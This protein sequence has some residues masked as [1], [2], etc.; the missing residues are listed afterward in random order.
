VSRSSAVHCHGLHDPQTRPPVPVGAVITFRRPVDR[1][2]SGSR[3][4]CPGSGPAGVARSRDIPRCGGALRPVGGRSRRS[5][6]P[7]QSHAP[8]R[9]DECAPFAEIAAHVARNRGRGR[10]RSVP[11]GIRTHVIGVKGRPTGTGRAR[12][13]GRLVVYSLACVRASCCSRR[14]SSM[15]SYGQPAP[16]PA[17]AQSSEQTVNNRVP[18]PHTST[19]AAACGGVV[20]LPPGRETE[21]PRRLPTRS[22]RCAA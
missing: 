17:P 20:P 7:A 10:K 12:N 22:P 15:V 21:N 14:S 13:E 2:L 19:P 6:I 8:H 3:S 9:G 16:E 18:S 11:G 4:R 5:A 1:P